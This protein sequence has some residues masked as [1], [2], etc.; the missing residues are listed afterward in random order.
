MKNT[1]MSRPKIWALIG[2]VLV[3]FGA[4]ITPFRLMSSYQTELRQAS[5]TGLDT[6]IFQSTY[7]VSGVFG[8]LLAV[9]ELVF[10]WLAFAK[11]DKKHGNGWAIFLLVMGILSVVGAFFT[12]VGFA[13]PVARATSFDSI[14]MGLGTIWGILSSLI[15]GVSFIMAFVVKHAE[16]KAEI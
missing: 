5:A 11:I 8:V 9:V 1:K 6:Q 7:I 13:S 12:L 4:L 2:A 3:S 15:V 10:I 16:R 14:G